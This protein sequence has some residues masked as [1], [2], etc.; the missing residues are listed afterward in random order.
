M[1][2]RSRASQ[3]TCIHEARD[4]QAWEEDARQLAGPPNSGK[5]TSAAW[6]LPGAHAWGPPSFSN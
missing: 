6:R 4:L 5:N 3:E 2:G 1:R